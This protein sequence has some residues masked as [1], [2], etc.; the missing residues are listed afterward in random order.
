MALK[1]WLLVFSS[2]FVQLTRKMYYDF[3]SARGVD[4]DI[5]L[6]SRGNHECDSDEAET[7]KHHD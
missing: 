4:D 1:E 2:Y 5:H 3:Y 7:I 6:G